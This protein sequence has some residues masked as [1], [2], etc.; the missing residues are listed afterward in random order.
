MLF[1]EGSITFVQAYVTLGRKTEK[2]DRWCWPGLTDTH[3]YGVVLAWEQT[4]LF[5]WAVGSGMSVSNMNGQDPTARGGTRK[6]WTLPTLVNRAEWCTSITPAWED[7]NSSANTQGTTVALIPL[8][9]AAWE[10]LILNVQIPPWGLLDLKGTTAKTVH[11]T[12]MEGTSW[13]ITS[14]L[15]SVQGRAY[16]SP[17]FISKLRLGRNTMSAQTHQEES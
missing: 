3:L 5:P 10:K 17:C 7:T 6:G 1:T 16:P 15:S 14:H 9:S 11:V 8:P 4:P 12:A 2:E 13:L